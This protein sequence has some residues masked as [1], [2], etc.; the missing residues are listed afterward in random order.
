[1]PL[2]AQVADDIHYVY[3]TP[4]VIREVPESESINP[5]LRQVILERSRLDR[6]QMK[7]NYGGWHSASTLFS[8]SSPEVD[9]LRQRVAEAVK[10]IT[11]HTTG[12][13]SISGEITITGWANVS[14][15]GDYNK[16]HHHPGVAWSG[17][18]YV[19]A[20]SA[21]GTRPD[22]GAIEFLDPRGAVDMVSYPGE[23]FSANFRITP[24]DGML[25]LFPAWL[26]HGVNRYD[27]E[28]ERIS[29]AFNVTIHQA[30]SAPA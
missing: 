27:G 21:S 11:A 30:S 7:S 24:I 8:W 14:R 28:G 26:E 9:V 23:P 3:P 29:I 4:L 10:S 16:P 2:H 25:V 18:Y 17:V 19:D 15:H 20:G 22:E 12:D 1:M 5:V 13:P 6:G